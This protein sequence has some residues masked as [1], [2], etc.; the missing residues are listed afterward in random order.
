MCVFVLSEIE[1]KDVVEYLK[2][3]ITACKE[4]AKEAGVDDDGLM[5]ETR[6]CTLTW[7]KGEEYKQEHDLITKA[8]GIFREKFEEL[9]SEEGK[10][11]NEV[12]I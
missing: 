12:P 7:L 2:A 1:D 4:V 5:K 10:A 9:F 6:K 11:K 3:G 8:Q